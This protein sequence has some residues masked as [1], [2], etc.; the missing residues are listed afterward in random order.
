MLS[1]TYTGFRLTLPNALEDVGIKCVKKFIL[2]RA[3][4]KLALLSKKITNW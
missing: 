2:M 4:K 3:W 1:K